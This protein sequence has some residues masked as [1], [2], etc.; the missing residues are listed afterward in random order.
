M[1]AAP[2]PPPRRDPTSEAVLRL[3]RDEP[4]GPLMATIAERVGDDLLLAFLRMT[5]ARFTGKAG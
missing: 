5:G 4:R 1:S 3:V 2:M